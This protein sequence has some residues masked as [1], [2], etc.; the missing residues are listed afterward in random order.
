MMHDDISVRLVAFGS[1]RCFQMQWAD[2]EEV[3]PDGTPK[4]HTRSTGVDR[5]LGRRGRDEAQRV[6]ERLQQELNANS[7]RTSGKV[8]WDAFRARYE[9]EHACEPNV[10]A[11]TVAQSH[12]SLTVSKGS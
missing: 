8:R 1:K 3:R 11:A 10:R 6:A 9:A 4:I 7:G 2:P 12:Q 5:S